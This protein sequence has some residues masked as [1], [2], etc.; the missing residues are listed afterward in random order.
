MRRKR[1]NPKGDWEVITGNW[2]NVPLNLAVGARNN[3]FMIQ[4]VP[5]VQAAT[6]LPVGSAFIAEVEFHCSILSSASI[7]AGMAEL[8][9]GLFV[10]E[11]DN[12]TGVW[13]TQGPTLQ[14][15]MTRDNWLVHKLEHCFL[16]LTGNL[17]TTMARSLSFH[18]RKPIRVAQG[19]ALCLVTE[20]SPNSAVAAF[21]GQSI[22][23]RVKRVW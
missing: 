14:A 20:N 9:V 21:I 22:R 23:F 18:Y 6:V 19:E 3:A 7:G 11:F 16:P 17:S 2:G 13:S 8:G 4:L 10:S 5:A 15:D 12:N 1:G